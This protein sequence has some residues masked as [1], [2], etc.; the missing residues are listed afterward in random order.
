MLKMNVNLL[1]M[2]NALEI[3]SWKIWNIDLMLVEVYVT[4]FSI[5]LIKFIL[6]SKI[7]IWI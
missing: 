3:I 2:I 5:A 6:N 4:C 7:I 1:V